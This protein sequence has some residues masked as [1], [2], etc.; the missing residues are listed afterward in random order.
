MQQFVE[1]ILDSPYNRISF[2]SIDFSSRGTNDKN[3][4]LISTGDEMKQLSHS[5]KKTNQ[6]LP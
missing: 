2:K 6:L 1:L 3:K 5:G 4:S